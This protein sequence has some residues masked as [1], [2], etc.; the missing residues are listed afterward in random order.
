MLLIFF[1]VCDDTTELKHPSE[2]NPI[3][4]KV[5]HCLRII[6]TCNVIKSNLVQSCIL[7]IVVGDFAC[8][9]MN[10]F[11]LQRFRFLFTVT[12]KHEVTILFNVMP[13]I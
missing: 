1:Y 4:F 8:E 13:E 12:K 7:V 11:E 10:D 3:F 9:F 5:K 2:K 6:G